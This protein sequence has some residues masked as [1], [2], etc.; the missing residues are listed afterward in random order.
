M[1]NN[2][3][4]MSMVLFAVFGILIGSITIGG[5]KNQKN[6]VLGII[7]NRIC[8][9][10]SKPILRFLPSASFF[11]TLLFDNA[12]LDDMKLGFNQLRGVLLVI[13]A[14]PA[15]IIL[16]IYLKGSKKVEKNKLFYST[17]FQSNIFSDQT[18]LMV[19]LFIFSLISHGTVSYVYFNNLSLSL[20]KTKTKFVWTNNTFQNSIL[21]FARFYHVNQLMFGLFIYHL[22]VSLWGLTSIISNISKDKKKTK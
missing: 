13:I 18:S 12:V 15:V 3:F 9:L 17:L 22:S 1:F 5:M 21:A 14:I 4:I 19:F 6:K 16:T 20:Q 8:W 10:F 7:N 2:E 11:A